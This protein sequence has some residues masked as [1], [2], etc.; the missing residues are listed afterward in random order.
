[1]LSFAVI[2]IRTMRCF[3]IGTYNKNESPKTKSI[4][5]DGGCVFLCGF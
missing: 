3:T 1:M 2:V 5:E 4:Q